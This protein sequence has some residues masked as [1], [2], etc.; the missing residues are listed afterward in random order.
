MPQLNLRSTVRA[1]WIAITVGFLVSF[2][3]LLVAIGLEI[4]DSSRETPLAVHFII[5][6]GASALTL[7]IMLWRDC[8]KGRPKFVQRGAHE[9]QSNR[10]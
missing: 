10:G 9:K 4:N 1:V 5:W 8:R 7:L 2:L 3:S 6:I